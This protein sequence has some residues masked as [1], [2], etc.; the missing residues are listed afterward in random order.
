VCVFNSGTIA[1]AF[2]P[3]KRD[4]RPDDGRLDVWIVSPRALWDYP[5]YL[6]N[7]LFRRHRQEFSHF[8]TV[9]GYIAIKS[10]ESMSLQAD[11]DVI[12]ATPIKIEVLPGAVGIIVP[13]D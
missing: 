4:I 13:A 5:G 1:R 11:G 9:K 2:Y 6:A 3:A 12:G 7:A 8:T 10:A